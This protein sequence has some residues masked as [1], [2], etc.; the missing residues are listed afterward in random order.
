MEIIKT[1]LDGVTILHPQLFEDN[2]GYFFESF[3]DQ[4]F[5]DLVCNTNFVQDNESKSSKGT[6]RGLHWQAPPFAQSK[7]VRVVKGAVLDVAVDVRIGSKTFGE[8][9]FVELTEDNHTQ[10][11]IPRGF[12]HGFLALEDNTIFQYKCDNVYNKQSE[13]AI[14]W[15]SINWPL[16][17]YGISAPLLSDKDLAHLTLQEVF[18]SKQKE[19]ILFNITDKL[20]D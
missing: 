2:R 19:S 12:A 13:K 1:S 5:K 18:Q 15:D 11:F 6:L 3:S 20:Y 8:Y 9:V 10:F 7:L 16:E 4:R 14:R 17:K